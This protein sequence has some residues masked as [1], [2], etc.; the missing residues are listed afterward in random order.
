[1]AL[2][3]TFQ[4]EKCVIEYQKYMGGVDRGNQIRERGGSFGKGIAPKKW[5][6]S[7]M[8]GMMDF[9]CLNAYVAWN[10]NAESSPNHHELTYFEFMLCLVEEFMNYDGEENDDTASDD[11]ETSQQLVSITTVTDTDYQHCS[12]HRP[13][14]ETHP[15]EN[16]N[17]RK[18]CC[19]VCLLEKGM[20]RKLKISDTRGKGSEISK[21]NLVK[22]K[23]CEHE[24]WLHD[25][26]AP[27]E[28]KIFELREFRGL[29]CFQ[30]YHHDKTDGLWGKPGVDGSKRSNPKASHPLYQQI[31]Q[32]YDLSPTIERTRRGV[33]TNEDDER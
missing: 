12:G 20:R 31:R 15:P 30:I 21:R 18:I 3:N 16:D 23:T 26:V 6:K 17:K 27:C 9:G 2:C 7:I 1:L 32:M 24:V 19:P 11:E 10:M 28:R 5:F 22:C 33:S 14:K 29:T 13:C 25:T 4:T 8:L